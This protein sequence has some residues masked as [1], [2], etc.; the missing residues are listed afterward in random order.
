MDAQACHQSVE[1]V[2]DVHVWIEK[3][4]AVPAE[5]DAVQDEILERLL[6]PRIVTS[7]RAK[8]RRVCPFGALRKKKKKKG[9]RE[10]KKGKR[11]AIS[12][13]RKQRKHS[14][15]FVSIV[16]RSNTSRRLF[17]E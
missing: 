17:R 3:L 9:G 2:L 14:G 12:D 15:L 10:E 4:R 11:T 13:Q 1:K 16:L 6:K 8:I 5:I 7:F